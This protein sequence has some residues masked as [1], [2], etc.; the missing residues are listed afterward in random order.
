MCGARV[1][2]G[3]ESAGSGAGGPGLRGKTPQWAEGIREVLTPSCC[4][5]DL[6]SQ[7]LAVRPRLR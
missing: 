6:S 4:L 2:A 5:G 3:A 1:G 7:Q